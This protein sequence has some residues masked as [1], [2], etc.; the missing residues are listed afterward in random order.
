LTPILKF[1]QRFAVADTLQTMRLNNAMVRRSADALTLPL[2]VA[3]IAADDEHNAATTYNLALVAN[4]LNA[5]FDFH[6][7]T[8]PSKDAAP[9]EAGPE[10]AVN[11]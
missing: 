9:G 5:G 7:D 10:M 6:D 2:L 8:F 11:A 3:G 4:T 1:Q